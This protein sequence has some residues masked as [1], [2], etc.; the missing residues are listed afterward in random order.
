[1]VVVHTRVHSLFL[2]LETTAS[3]A[4]CDS[5]P[6]MERL[7]QDGWWA[8][9]AARPDFNL[10]SAFPLDFPTESAPAGRAAV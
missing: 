4:V 2:Q 6:R 10:H 9:F 1:M 7:G 8:F 5:P 3:F